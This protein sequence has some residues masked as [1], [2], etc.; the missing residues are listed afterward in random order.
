[1]TSAL[2]SVSLPLMPDFDTAHI[3]RGTGSLKWDKRPDLQPFWVADMDF[4]SPPAVVDALQR[5]VEHGIFGYPVPH[6]GLEE[7]IL[8]YLERRHHTAVPPAQI[9]HLGGLV[10]AL[11]LAGRAFAESGDALMTCTPVYPP[12]LGIHRDGALDLITVP[13]V[14]DGDRWIFDWQAMEDAVTP[15]TRLFVLSN[16]QNPLGRVF[17]EAEVVQLGEFCARHDLILISDEIHCDLIY[18][19]DATPFFSALRLPADLAAR[20]V[21]LLSPS[22]TYNIAGLGYAYAVIPDKTLRQRFTQARGH[23]LAEINCLAYY[24]AE[25]AYQ[26]GEPWRRDLIAYLR[27]N[28]DLLTSF[29]RD[30]L[31][32]VIIPDME[33]TYLAWLDFRPRGIDEPASLLE[34]KVGVFL[35]DGR[36]FGEPGHARLNF[37][38]SRSLLQEALDAIASALT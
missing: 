37:G 38:C 7:A 17:S 18:D 25:A 1:L 2:R 34:K 33:A 15:R 22:K 23:T 35:S 26:H 24:A 30:E 20:S 29:V 11:S 21:V 27:G 16:P 19:D 14:L 5:R 32:T 6:A 8:A 36:F 13:H 3:R 28:R 9:V 31:K 10:P 12:F 4:Q